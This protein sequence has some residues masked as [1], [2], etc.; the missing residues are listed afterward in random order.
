MALV[1]LFNR[2]ETFEVTEFIDGERTDFHFKAERPRLRLTRQL[3]SSTLIR[4]QTPHTHTSQTCI[5][6][7]GTKSTEYRNKPFLKL[8]NISYTLSTLLSFDKP[9]LFLHRFFLPKRANSEMENWVLSLS[10]VP[11]VLYNKAWNMK[12]PQYAV[13]R[14]ESSTKPLCFKQPS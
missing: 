1:G 13:K 2:I 14:S 7:F 5:Y 8:S 9:G 6:S 4:Y 12:L 10:R 11:L 3:D